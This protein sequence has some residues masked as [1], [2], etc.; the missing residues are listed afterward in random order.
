[1][2]EFDEPGCRARGTPPSLPVYYVMCVQLIKA[3]IQMCLLAVSGRWIPASRCGCGS[4]AAT[5][6]HSIDS[7]CRCRLFVYAPV[8]VNVRYAS[9]KCECASVRAHVL[10]VWVCMCTWGPCPLS[11][12]QSCT[13]KID[14]TSTGKPSHT[15]WACGGGTV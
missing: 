8:C 12:L 5:G 2:H 6:Q 4:R 11:A 10:C 3:K 9:S 14:E 15:P 7:V 1:M 13:Y